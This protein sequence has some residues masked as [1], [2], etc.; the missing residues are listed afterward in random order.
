[1]SVQKPHS[2][3]K[4]QPSWSLYLPSRLP[5]YPISSLFFD[6][7][8]VTQQAPPD[9]AHALLAYS[10]GLITLDQVSLQ[11]ISVLIGCSR[12]ELSQALELLDP[13]GIYQAQA[14]GLKPGGR[15]SIDNVAIT[16]E[17]TT[18][19]EGVWRV[20]CSSQKRQVLGHDFVAWFYIDPDGH[21]TL[22]R[23]QRWRPDGPTRIELAQAGVALLLSWG[24]RPWLVSFDNGFLEP[25]FCR[26]LDQQGL[27]WVS[28]VRSNQI[29]YV[30]SQLRALREWAKAVSL[31]SWH[32]YGRRR[33]Y[34]KAAEVANQAYG[35]VKVV[36]VKWGRS[37]PLKAHRYYITNAR[38]A[39]VQ[40]ILGWYSSR[41][42]IEVCFRDCRQSLGMDQYR[43]TEAVKAEGHMALVVV[44]YNFLQT[45]GQGANMPIGQLKR[46]A[47]GRPAKPRRTKVS[48]L[49]SLRKVS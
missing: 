45:M 10:S 3:W 47:Q 48:A 6:R 46:L 25:E 32:Y 2:A 29:F 19:T 27:W 8:L 24:V 38:A 23:L 41:W 18:A 44:A 14:Q 34:A 5:Y 33:V 12:E 11:G 30:G 17:H 15:L 35:R 13:D 39:S 1:M 16:K 7:H 37:A 31:D 21:R 42:P 28:R 36:A 26:W 20:H 43:F 40:E 9:L 49:S 22:L 4:G